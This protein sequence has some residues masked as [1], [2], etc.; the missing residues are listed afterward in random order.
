MANRADGGV[1]GHTFTKKR[2]ARKSSDA[3][4]SREDEH[5][6][7]APD[8]DEDELLVDSRCE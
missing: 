2:T 8:A 5:P 6:D 7:D 3:E 4:A 1:T